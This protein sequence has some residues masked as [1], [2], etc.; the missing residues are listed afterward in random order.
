MI[1]YVSLYRFHVIKLIELTNAFSNVKGC[2]IKS[3]K[4]LYTNDKHS[5]EEIR[6]SYLFITTPPHIL[7]QG[8]RKC[9]IGKF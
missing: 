4:F 8:Y 3:I 7:N 2:K 6:E 1:L 9:L 5:E